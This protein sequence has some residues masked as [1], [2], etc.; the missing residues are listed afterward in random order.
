MRIINKNAKGICFAVDKSNC[1]KGTVTD[2]DIRRALLNDVGLDEKIGNILSNEFCYVSITDKY[3]TLKSKITDKIS[4]I[5]LVDDDFKVVDFFEYKQNL[6]FPV[7]IPSLNGNEL[8]YL[9]D[10]F[11]STWISSSGEYIEKFENE[12]STYSDCKFG[13]AVSMVQ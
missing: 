8:K 11:M 3:D 6:N 12:F 4:I 5:P 2:G 13:A 10:A 9:T 7:A 1:L